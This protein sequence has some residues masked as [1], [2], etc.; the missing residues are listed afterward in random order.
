MWLALLTGSVAACLWPTVAVELRLREL[1]AE[2]K[3]VRMEEALARRPPCPDNAAPLYV[4]AA[5]I[6]GTGPL[7][8]GQSLNV[9]DAAEAAAWARC[10][11]PA[12]DLLREAARR[13]GCQFDLVRQDDGIVWETWRAPLMVNTID[14]LAGTA[15]S[16]SLAG[17]RELAGEC[18]LMGYTVSRHHVQ[19][20]LPS[21]A[22]AAARL[23]RRM[24]RAAGRVLA[25]SKLTLPDARRLADELEALDY[26]A[27]SRRDAANAFHEAVDMYEFLQRHPDRGPMLMSSRGRSSSGGV[28][29]LS[30]QLMPF[31][32][33]VHGASPL[34]NLDL[35]RTLDVL[36]QAEPLWALTWREARVRWRSLGAEA[37]RIG[38]PP[39]PLAWGELLMKEAVARDEAIAQRALLRAA[40]ALYEHK[41]QHDA[42]PAS[43][44]EVHIEGLPIPNDVFS[45]KPFIYRR[46]GDGFVLYSI[47]VNLKDDGGRGARS[48]LEGDLPWPPPAPPKQAMSVGTDPAGGDDE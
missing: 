16:A 37:S 34:V 39:F 15:V 12:L 28:L 25:A 3:P 42:F 18:L 40:L 9:S 35:A 41:A 45:G 32:V 11:A 13:T 30:P 21:Q 7:Q 8:A 43:L 4:E 44:S 23:D 26:M 48:F 27:V 36:R 47:G 46:E 20:C 17:D 10:T 33:F 5:R 29:G 22:W 31:G 38:Y 6:T 2:G 24:H 1:R 19:D 14:G